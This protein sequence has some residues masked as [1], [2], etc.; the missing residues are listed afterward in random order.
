MET[1]ETRVLK[2]ATCPSLSGK[3]KLTYELGC[4]PGK[5]LRIRI[6]KNSRAGWFSA[7]WVNW[8]D[9]LS[10]LATNARKEITSFTLVP[11]YKGRS[12]NTGGFLLAALKH[13]GLVW[14]M[15]SSPRCCECL[16]ASAFLAEMKA[17]MSSPVAPGKA[18]KAAKAVGTANV[19][20]LPAAKKA[21]SS[22]SA[23]R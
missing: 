13:E 5:D 15:E 11:L 1:N 20:A 8:P 19:V 10:A 3:S 16:D 17:L 22:R 4:G 7:D 23:G 21:V 18:A 14:N 12:V 6:V 2:T 9:L